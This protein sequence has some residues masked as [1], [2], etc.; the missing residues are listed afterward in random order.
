MTVNGQVA[1][2]LLDSVIQA[3]NTRTEMSVAVLK[4]AQEIGREQGEAMIQLLE[5]SMPAV[6]GS[7]LDA[8]A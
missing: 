2:S 4:K 7:T 5:T 8:Y 1:I 6:D 3:E